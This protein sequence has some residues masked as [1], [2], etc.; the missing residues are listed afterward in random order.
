[1]LNLKGI[2]YTPYKTGTNGT[3]KQIRGNAQSILHGKPPRTF[4]RITDNGGGLLR[5]LFYTNKKN[6]KRIKQNCR[7]AYVMGCKN[8]QN[9]ILI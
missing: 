5:V 7:Q 1:M 2:Y 9:G 8:G 6:K 3:D 4:F